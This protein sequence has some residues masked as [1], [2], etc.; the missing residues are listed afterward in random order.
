MVVRRDPIKPKP[1]IWKI[2]LV[3]QQTAL[4]AD[5]LAAK[6]KQSLI[7]EV[8]VT[9]LEQPIHSPIEAVFYAWWEAIDRHEAGHGDTL[10]GLELAP[11]VSV[12][13]P[14]DFRC[15]PD[16]MVFPADIESW[17]EAS[18]LGLQYQHI[19]VELDGHDFHERTKE[20]VTERNRRDRALQDAGWRVF[21]FSGSELVRDPER[22]VREVRVVAEEALWR[23]LRDMRARR[24]A[25]EQHAPPAAKE[26][27][28][29]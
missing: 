8:R 19:A 7:D 12:S 5:W 29:P 16:F 18:D 1:E 17:S 22:C 10:D 13:L 9:I 11:Q 23:M 6:S 21:H 15:R 25:Q 26:P 14:N 28:V 3:Q 27:D 24:H 2:D 4:A 20:Q